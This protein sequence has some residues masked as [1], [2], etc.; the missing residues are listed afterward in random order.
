MKVNDLHGALRGI[1]PRDLRKPDRP[2]GQPA[3][4]TQETADGD[5]LD[6][7]L[8]AHVSARSTENA[9][10][11]SQDASSLTPA[12]TAEIRDRIQAGFYNSPAILAE[13]AD[14]LLSFYSK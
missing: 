9:A 14:R 13:S 12:R 11:A 10:A 5:S 2:D 1:D 4:Q 7:T 8:S 6:L 3:S